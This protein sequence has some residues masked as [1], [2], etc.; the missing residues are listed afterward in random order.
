MVSLGGI[1]FLSF[2]KFVHL[3]KYYKIHPDAI[4]SHFVYFLK[5]LSLL[6][7]L[8][9]ST[10]NRWLQVRKFVN[11]IRRSLFKINNTKSKVRQTENR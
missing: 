9:V 1:I 5:F 3:L 8:P 10:V 2:A 11:V 4:A 7:H 6:F